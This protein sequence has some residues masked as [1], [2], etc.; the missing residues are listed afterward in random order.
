M[1]AMRDRTQP[2][3]DASAEDPARHPVLEWLDRT[4]LTHVPASPCHYLPGEVARERA[5]VASRL[6][7]AGYQALMDRGFRRSGMVFYRPDC[8]ACSLCV[9]LRVPVATFQPTRSQRRVQR[10]NADITLTMRR[11]QCSEATFGLYRRYLDFQHPDPSRERTYEGFRESFYAEVVDS[12]EAVYTLGE[13][14]VAISLLDVCAQSVSAVY[15]F[16]E[17]ELAGRSLGVCSVLAEIAWARAQGV[18]YYYLGYWVEGAPT[19]AYK[20]SYG[21]HELLR[22]GRWQPPTPSP[23]P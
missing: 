13:R 16:F 3:P 14:V 1:D 19:M 10:K 17:P 9:P 11:P 15:H 12:L 22:E 7:G 21:P 18:P 6:D 5:F 8:P 4:T 23:A 20:A 2:G